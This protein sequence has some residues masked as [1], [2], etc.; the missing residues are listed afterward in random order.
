MEQGQKHQEEKAFI[1][2]RGGARCSL[3]VQNLLHCS[4]S[5][6]I[7]TQPI[8]PRWKEG[9]EQ[10]PVDGCLQRAAGKSLQLAEP[11]EHFGAVAAMGY[12]KCSSRRNSCTCKGDGPQEPTC[13]ELQRS[14][15]QQQ[16]HQPHTGCAAGGT[17]TKSYSRTEKI[18]TK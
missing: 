16:C 11:P 18:L 9:K 7:S 12:G 2:R 5:R 14:E 13:K 3:R 10:I 8:P 1:L 17:A 4:H 6:A 15:G